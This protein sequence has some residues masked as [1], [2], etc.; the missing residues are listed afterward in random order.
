MTIAERFWLTALILTLTLLA[1]ILSGFFYADQARSAVYE[2]MVAAERQLATLHRPA[3]VEQ[4]RKDLADAEA[5]V[6]ST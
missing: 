6:Q 4:L 2:R 3:D 1:V 5:R